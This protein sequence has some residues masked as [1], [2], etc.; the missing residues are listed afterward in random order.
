MVF[1]LFSKERALKR[2]LEK[3][4]NKLAQHVDR[5]AAMEKLRDN[6]TD[7]AI[8]GL[9]RRFSFSYDKSVE[10]E[11]EKQWVV[12][13]LT[14]KGDGILPPLKRYIKSAGSIAYPL[15]ILGR[16]ASESQVLEVI[17]ELIEVEEP[18]YARDP[19]KKMQMIDWLAEWSTGKDEDV[20]KRIAPYLAD[21]DEGVRFAATEALGQRPHECAAEALAAALT[22]PEEESGRLK[23]RI[24][25]VMAAGEMALGDKK[26]AISDLV[27]TEL[28]GFHLK[29]DKLHKR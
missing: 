10:D 7:E 15:E 4:N 23:L 21:F 24:A 8:Y 5:W 28:D 22:R 3:A 29:H 11:Q 17:D 16:V 6:G 12:D 13:S 18:G 1:G 19:T 25:E 2:A 20:A 26:D 14:A 27:K 9:L